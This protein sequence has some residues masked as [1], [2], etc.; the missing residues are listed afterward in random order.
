MGNFNPR[1]SYEGRLGSCR[2][3]LHSA[4][5]NP[6]PSYEGRQ[7]NIVLIHLPDTILSQYSEFS[8]W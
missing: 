7:L 8:A 3:F 6:R 2:I 4:N 1:P 5:F